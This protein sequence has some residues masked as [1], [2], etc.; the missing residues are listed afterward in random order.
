M[1]EAIGTSYVFSIMM[2]FVGVMIALV[3]GSI[4]YSKGF[5][6]R[7]RVID[8]IQR[9]EGYPGR[10]N[11]ARREIEENLRT[12]GYRISDRECPTRHHRDTELEFQHVAVIQESDFRYCIYRFETTRGNYYGVT[13][14]ITFDLPLI[15]GLIEIPVYGETRLLYNTGL[16][17]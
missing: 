12:I 11:I 7:N 2:V 10:E 14:F 9:H 4:A 1:K 17:Y 5:R 8:I 13:V 3:V 16:N 15:G 6:V